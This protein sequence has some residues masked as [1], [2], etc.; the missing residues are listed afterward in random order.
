MEKEKLILACLA[1]ASGSS[2]DPAQIQKLVFLY[3]ERGLPQGETKPFRF[4]PYNFGPFDPSVYFTLDRL[5]EKGLVDIMGSPLSKQRSYRLSPAGVGS[6]EIA[7]Q[8]VPS[9]D[10]LKQLSDWVKKQSF[11]SLIAAVYKAFPEMKVNSVFRT[12]LSSL[13]QDMR[14]MSMSV[15]DL[16]TQVTTQA[17]MQNTIVIPGVI[18]I[19]V[20]VLIDLLCKAFNH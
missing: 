18:A 19:F 9:Y 5:S 12:S 10:Y 13:A 7:A 11:T 8:E 20:G 14:T 1:A 6:A 15:K 16:T 4:K 3:Q 2:Y 17:T